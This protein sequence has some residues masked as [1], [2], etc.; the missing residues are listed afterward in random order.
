MKSLPLA[1]RIYVCGI[2]G[3]GAAMLIAFFPRDFDRS[4]WLFL[5][6][7]LLSSITSVFKVNLP[8]ARR[9]STMSV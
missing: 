5:S 4:P 1:A 7:L 6:L 3:V 8:L 9:S 2:I